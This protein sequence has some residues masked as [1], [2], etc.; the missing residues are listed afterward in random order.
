MRIVEGGPVVWRPIGRGPVAAE[1]ASLGDR[2]AIDVA[3]IVSALRDVGY[4][5]WFSVHQ[6][7]Q[8]GQSVED[9]IRESHVALGDLVR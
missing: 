3:E 7:L 4:D 5:G 8:P 9:A 1:Y 2:A 6:P